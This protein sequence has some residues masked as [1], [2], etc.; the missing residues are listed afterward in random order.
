LHSS[1][2]SGGS[3]GF[4]FI[5]GNDK[6][7]VNFIYLPAGSLFVALGI[8]Q[9]SLLA[10]IKNTLGIFFVVTYDTSG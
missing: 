6:P 8:P 5:G 4:L 3:G 10:K 1:K 2:S 9:V 7:E